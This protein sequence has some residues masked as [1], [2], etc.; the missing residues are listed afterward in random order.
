MIMALMIMLIVMMI[1]MIIMRI[2]GYSNNRKLLFLV[3]MVIIIPPP[4]LMKITIM[5]FKNPIHTYILLSSTPSLDYP[6]PLR[7]SFLAYF[8]RVL[9]SPRRI[10]IKKKTKLARNRSDFY[11]KVMEGPAGIEEKTCRNGLVVLSSFLYGFDLFF[12]LMDGAKR[13]GK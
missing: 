5:N 7:I 13:R 11:P 3:I 1:V 12:G 6:S 8:R 9:K 4:T 10:E 2:I